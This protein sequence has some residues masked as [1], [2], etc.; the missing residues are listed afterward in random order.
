MVWRVGE[1]F[2]SSHKE[3]YEEA[4]VPRV[5]RRELRRRSSALLADVEPVLVARGH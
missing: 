1:G 5:F 3:R 4:A 2:Q